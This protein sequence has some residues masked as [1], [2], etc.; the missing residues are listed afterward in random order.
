MQLKIYTGIGDKGQTKQVTGHMVPK[1]DL[2]IET[3]GQIDELDSWL[4][5]T[6]ASLSLKNKGLAPTIKH[7][8][9]KLYELQADI[10]IKR[11]H[12]IQE[13]DV[14]A[15]EKKIDKLSNEIPVIKAFI[16]PGGQQTGANL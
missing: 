9:H 3:L 11:Y 12:N 16:L 15:L 6:C 7:L 13:K 5:V 10:A 14:D 1:Y 8:Q 4:G 2:Q